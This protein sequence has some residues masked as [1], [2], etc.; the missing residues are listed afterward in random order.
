M[1]ATS[2]IATRRMR[3]S[4]R[5]VAALFLLV[6]ASLGA[7]SGLGSA[8]LGG[9]AT[10]FDPAA[11]RAMGQ[12]PACRYDDIL[13]TPR[14]YVDWGTTLVDPILRVPSTYAPPDLVPVGD[15]SIGGI[16]A[17][18]ELAIGE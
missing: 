5:P 15:A 13:T 6:A 1:H 3:M 4:A 17:V 16:G 10:P 11:A 2:P 9:G 12:L 7:A 18:R 8:A 14:K